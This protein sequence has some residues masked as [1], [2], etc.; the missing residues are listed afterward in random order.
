MAHI[1]VAGRTGRWSRSREKTQGG[2][3]GEGDRREEEVKAKQT[4]AL[5]ARGDGAIAAEGKEWRGDRTG[6]GWR[7]QRLPVRVIIAI[8]V[9]IIVSVIMALVDVRIIGGSPSSPGILR[10][11]SGRPS[12]LLP[13]DR[14][15]FSVL[16]LGF[17]LIVCR[18]AFFC[19]DLSSN[20]APR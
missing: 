16:V 3:H 15:C 19:L 14:R 9:V 2:E 17:S 20:V 12:W 1:A 5:Q 11:T 10:R 13:V 8:V 6:E 4:P 18:S 7:A